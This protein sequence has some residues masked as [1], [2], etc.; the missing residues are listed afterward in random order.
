MTDS[1]IIRLYESS[2]TPA[3]CCIWQ[4]AFGDEKSLILRF[5]ELLP[6]MGKG[7]AAES[8]GEVVGMLYMLD[9]TCGKKKIGYVYAVAVKKELR[10]H[11]IGRM[12]CEAA[13]KMDYDIIATLPAEK[14][15]Y[16][17]YEKVLGTKPALY[18]KHE[19]LLPC[20]GKAFY[21]ID[22][23]E[24]GN[25]RSRLLR[26]KTHIDFPDNYLRFQEEIC[27]TYGGGMYAGS[28]G[29]ACGYVEDGILYIKEALGDTSFLPALCEAL[30]AS[31]AVIRTSA[32]SGEPFIA[33]V[34]ALPLDCE[35]NL[36]LD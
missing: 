36:A 13:S 19:K 21:E 29:I 14:G 8:N 35:W 15:L 23:I 9:A 25:I 17:W 12:L 1:I 22:A 11:G 5:F 3:L 26:G 6:D 28:G 30:G 2:D 7:F 27:R 31:Y 24:Y 20:K 33:A 18:G 10:G 16:A 32:C 34:G 4:D